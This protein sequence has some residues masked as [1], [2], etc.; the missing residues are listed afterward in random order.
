MFWWFKRGE[1]FIG[2]EARQVGSDFFELTVRQPD[3]SE[4]VERL[5]DQQ[6]LLDRQRA[7]DSELAGAGWTGPHGW[8]L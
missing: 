3:G 8:N 4:R 6:A 5:N 7:L 2:Y 1:Q